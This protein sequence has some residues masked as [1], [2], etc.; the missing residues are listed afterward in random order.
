MSVVFA[1]VNCNSL[2]VKTGHLRIFIIRYFKI[3]QKNNIKKR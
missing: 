2:V 3:A 1:D